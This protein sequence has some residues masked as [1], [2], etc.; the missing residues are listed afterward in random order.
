MSS[1]GQAICN[2]SH[3]HVHVSSRG[4]CSRAAPP[5]N[6]V[7]QSKQLRL[8]NLSSHLG[9]GYERTSH[10]SGPDLSRMW[11]NVQT[12]SQQAE[13]E[14]RCAFSHLNLGQHLGLVILPAEAEVTLRL[15]WQGLRRWRR[16]DAERHPNH[17]GGATTVAAPTAAPVMLKFGY[18]L[19][20][21]LKS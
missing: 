20:G 19:Q 6:T 13:A 11:T 15:A 7:S 17:A 16:Q 4:R 9:Y 12:A 2:D 10:L 14:A 3:A 21:M 18:E 1:A 8:S 5:K